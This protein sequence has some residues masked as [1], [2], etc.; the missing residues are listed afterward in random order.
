VVDREELLELLKGFFVATEV[1]R[2]L[3]RGLVRMVELVG[4]LVEALACPSIFL[5]PETYLD[6]RLLE[7]SSGLVS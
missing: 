2:F 1:L 3:L 4:P 5:S 6:V 7:E